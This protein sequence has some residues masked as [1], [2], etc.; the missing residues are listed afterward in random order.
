LIRSANSCAR[1]PAA[2]TQTISTE[3]MHTHTAMCARDKTPLW[4]ECGE[5]EYRITGGKGAI[6]ARCLVQARLTHRV[7]LG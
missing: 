3:H 7:R 6:Q 4:G 2:A 5:R 1:R